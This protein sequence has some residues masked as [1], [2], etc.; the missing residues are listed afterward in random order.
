MV[1]HFFPVGWMAGYWLC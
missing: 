1:R